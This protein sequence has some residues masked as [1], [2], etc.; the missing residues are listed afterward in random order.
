MGDMKYHI[1]DPQILAVSV[2]NLVAPAIWRPNFYTFGLPINDSPHFE[3]LTSRVPP[4]DNHRSK[5][6]GILTTNP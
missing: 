1:Q 3:D 2:Q 6:K 5:F 4:N